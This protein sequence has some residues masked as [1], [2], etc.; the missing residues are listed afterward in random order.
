MFLF[1]NANVS[2]LR[3]PVNRFGHVF[4]YIAMQGKG[5]SSQALPL[6]DWAH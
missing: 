6:L 1:T 4:Y 2:V 3:G 5:F